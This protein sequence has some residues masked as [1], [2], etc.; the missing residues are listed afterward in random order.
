MQHP[1]FAVLSV[2]GSWR[3][4]PTGTPTTKQ[5]HQSAVRGLADGL[6]EHHPEVGPVELDRQDIR[7]WL[8]EV[9]EGNSSNTARG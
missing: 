6:A 4:G 3:C 7:G 8:V 2:S 9:R 1:D 5:S